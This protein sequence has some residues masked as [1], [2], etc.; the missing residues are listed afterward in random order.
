MSAIE[1]FKTAIIEIIG[2]APA[3]IMGD[4]VLHRFKIGGKPN[5]WYVLHTDGTAAGSFGDWKTGIKYKWKAAFKVNSLTAAERKAYAK[6]R[7]EDEI[8]RDA[9]EAAKHK[10]AAA[11]AV[12]I[13]RNAKPANEDHPYLLR[14]NIQP[15]DARVSLDNRLIIPLFNAKKELV[16]LQFISDDGT[17]R[18]LSG[19]QKKGCFNYFGELTDTILIC[20]GFATGA[21][22]HEDT[23]YL[24]VIAFDAGN[25]EPVAKSIKSIRPRHDILICGDNDE[26]GVG[27]SKAIA[28]ARAIGAKYVLPPIVGMDFNDYVN[29]EVAL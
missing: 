28:A 8:R 17:K 12:Y 7:Q 23:G 27:E 26:S 2:E 11:K 5:G 1:Q 24:T 13:W 9:E 29:M 21:S 6:Q 3:E 10:A 25:L 14:K 15:H 22:L 19:G 20:E 18:F 16:N 4:G